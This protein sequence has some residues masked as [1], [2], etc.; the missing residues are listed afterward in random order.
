MVFAEESTT[1]AF[2]LRARREGVRD[3]GAC[4]A[5]FTAFQMLQGIETLPL[6]MARHVENTRA[7]V[8]FLR[9]ASVGRERRLSG[10]A[11]PSRPCARGAAA[12]A[13]L[14]RGVQLQPA[15]HARARAARFIESLR[16]F[17]HLA[18]VGDA[19]SLV[20]HPASTTHFRM[21]ADGPRARGHRRRH[22][23]PV[24]RPR[25]SRTTSSRTSAARCTPRARPDALRTS[26]GRGRVYAYTGARR[27]RRGAA[28]RACSCTA[29]ATTTACGRCSRATSRITAAMCSRVDLPGHGRSAGPA[30]DDRSR[31]SPRGSPTPLD[32]RRH[33]TRTPSSGH[34]LGALSAL[35]LRGAAA[36]R[37]SSALALLGPAAPMPVSD[38]LLDGGAHDEPRAAALDHRLVAHAPRISSAATG[39]RACG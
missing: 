30:A 13:R 39:C 21:S 35:A 29:P 24:D 33:R 22:D 34:S 7:V 32:A 11:R 10:A 6:R 28:D 4:M 23:P 27:A 37:A 36:R 17:S 20:I 9:D 14:R 8:A 19:K 1:A 16:L 2:L 18:N 5:P 25:G 26:R 38:A 15:R 12:A 3:F 31:R